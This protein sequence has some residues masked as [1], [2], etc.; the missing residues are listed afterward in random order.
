MNVLSLRFQVRLTAV[1][2]FVRGR[3]F[4]D[5]FQAVPFGLVAVALTVVATRPPA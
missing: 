1:P 5:R 2:F 4:I 3:L